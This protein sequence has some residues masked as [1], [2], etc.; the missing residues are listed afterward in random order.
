[1]K[2]IFKRIAVV[3]LAAISICSFAILSACGGSKEDKM[4][5]KITAFYDSVV[6][7]QKCLDETADDIYSY[8]YD[9]IYKDKYLGNI[10]YAIAAA[11][12]DNKTNLETIEANEPIIQSLYKEVRNSEL[13]DEIKDVMSAYSDYYEFVVNVSGSFNS[14]SASKETLKK[15]LAS[16]LK[17]LQLEI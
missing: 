6:A 17:A 5:D 7:S 1:M 2:K 10:N 11:L 13:E 9:A 14:F 16:S 4:A 15:K 12:D 3:I 8:W